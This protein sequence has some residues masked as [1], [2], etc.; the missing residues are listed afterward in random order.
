MWLS[1]RVDQG[2]LVGMPFSCHQLGPLENAT[3]LI[4]RT[5]LTFPRRL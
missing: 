1:E 5:R 2:G 3:L 4:C